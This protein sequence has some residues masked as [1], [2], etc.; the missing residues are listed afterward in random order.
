MEKRPI[1]WLPIS[2]KPTVLVYVFI[3]LFIQLIATADHYMGSKSASFELTMGAYDA[4]Y[5]ELLDSSHEFRIPEMLNIR[6]TS[7]IDTDNYRLKVK[8]CWATARYINFYWST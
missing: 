2:W 5:N 4:G 7:N 1:S 6:A 8:E 3:Y